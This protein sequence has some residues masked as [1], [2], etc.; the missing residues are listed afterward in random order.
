MYIEIFLVIEDIFQGLYDNFTEENMEES[1]ENIETI[2]DVDSSEDCDTLLCSGYDDTGETNLQ[3]NLPQYTS[4]NESL[5][6]IEDDDSLSDISCS[7]NIDVRDELNKETSIEIPEQ[8]IIVSDDLDDSD[9]DIEIFEPLVQLK[10]NIVSGATKNTNL[11]TRQ[12][13]NNSLNVK[14]VFKHNASLVKFNPSVK[15]NQF[16]IASTATVHRPKTTTTHLQPESSAN[17]E[18]G[19]NKSFSRPKQQ[20]KI[21]SS[22][23]KKSEV[24]L[25]PHNGINYMISKGI[26]SRS[27]LLKSNSSSSTT[28]KAPSTVIRPTEQKNQCMVMSSKD[29][30][31]GG[32]KEEFIPQMQPLPEGK[33]KMVPDKG[34]VPINL[35]K[36]CKQNSNFTKQNF[37]THLTPNENKVSDIFH[38]GNSYQLAN[39]K[40]TRQFQHKTLDVPSVKSSWSKMS[41]IVELGNASRNKKFPTHTVTSK[42]PIEKNS[43]NFVQNCEVK[44]NKNCH[45]KMSSSPR[46]IQLSSNSKSLKKSDSLPLSHT[47]YGWYKILFKSF[48]VFPLTTFYLFQFR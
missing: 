36:V 22:N 14:K 42:D 29:A 44:I 20:L 47:R 27:P 28:L 48:F 7:G 5:M 37:S 31:R 18:I 15:S 24:Y 13:E 2:M 35:E 10:K 16:K 39:I 4:H 23:E 17:T 25:V 8:E 6:V 45:Q 12:K 32:N 3:C 34:Q 30:L 1:D 43:K 46:F 21:T 38:I 26:P 9:S 33:Y 11:F 40:K 19:L 41:K